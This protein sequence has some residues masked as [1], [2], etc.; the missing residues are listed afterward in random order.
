MDN[1]LYSSER[2]LSD[3]SHCSAYTSGLNIECLLPFYSFMIL[4][5]TRRIGILLAIGPD[6]FYD[7]K[8]Q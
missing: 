6:I 3:G 2:Y 8:N 4:A 5:L 7:A 1:F